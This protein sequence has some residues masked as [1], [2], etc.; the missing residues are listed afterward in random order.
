METNPKLISKNLDL[1]I[2]TIS[3]LESVLKTSLVA[4]GLPPMNIVSPASNSNEQ[5]ELG[6][7]TGKVEY[8]YA[9]IILTSIS[10][11]RTTYNDGLRRVGINAVQDSNL[12]SNFKLT[13]ITLNL[14]FKYSCQSYHEAIKF[15]KIWLKSE[16]LIQ[17]MLVSNN[18]SLH[19]KVEPSEDITFPE[20]NMAEQANLFVVETTLVVYT[21]DGEFNIKPKLTKLGVQMG[22][23]KDD[24]TFD[25]ELDTIINSNKG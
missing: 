16:P 10:R 4:K 11:N 24:G 22:L 13:P 15:S 17:F 1:I 8:P 25:L 5:R 2:D 12:V 6:R 21:Y 14:T 18:L 9:S 23:Q 19:I 3:A 7:I 20:I